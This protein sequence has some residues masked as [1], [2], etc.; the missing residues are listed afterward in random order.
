MRNICY[1]LLYIF[2]TFR[3]LLIVFGGLKGLENSLEADER[4]TI[5]DPCLL[6]D[7]YLNTCPNQGSGTIRTEVSRYERLTI[8]DPCLIIICRVRN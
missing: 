6:F 8:Q 4:L 5:Q 1:S 2:A 3:H 7:H